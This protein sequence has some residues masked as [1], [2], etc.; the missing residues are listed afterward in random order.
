LHT[1]RTLKITLAYEG[2]DL[3]GW[4]RQPEGASVQAA[5][6]AALARLEGAPVAAIG[7][8]RTDA[9]VHAARQVASARVDFRHDVETIGRALNAALPEA[10]RVLEVADAPDTFHARFSALS[11]TYH[12]RVTNG[13]VVSP[14]A[15]RWT[16]HV[17]WTLDIAAMEAAAAH[18]A[19]E[20][21]FA[22]FQSVGS[23]IATTVRRLHVS[24]FIEV[25]RRASAAGLAPH[26]DPACDGRLFVYE[27]RGTGFLR[28]M[29]RAIVGT[30][31]E[32]GSGRLRPDDVARLLERPDRSKAGPTAPACGLCLASVEYSP[33]E[34]EHP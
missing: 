33:A 23:D 24:R 28:H 29:V 14:F 19:G 10:I 8:G 12:Y 11:K 30:L 5:L 13:P 3:V 15:R 31:V 22:A 25:A 18:L 16:W 32:V 27:V 4:Q 9:G 34:S 21:D 1:V 2:T 26:P 20:H 6:E 17:P 7:A